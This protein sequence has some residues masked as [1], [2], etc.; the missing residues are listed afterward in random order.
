MSNTHNTALSSSQPAAESNSQVTLP[1]HPLISGAGLDSLAGICETLDFCAAY[2]PL[3]ADLVVGDG[4][5]C[6]QCKFF[7]FQQITSTGQVIEAVSSALDRKYRVH[8]TPDE[9]A[10]YRA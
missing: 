9:P 8:H 7:I 4:E 3:L 5:W 10:N 6:D 1:T 2:L